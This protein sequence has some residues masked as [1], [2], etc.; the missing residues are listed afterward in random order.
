MKELQRT[1]F[2]AA[3]D[4]VV[5][6]SGNSVTDKEQREMLRKTSLNSGD[7]DELTL[8]EQMVL[9]INQFRH[10]YD[11]VPVAVNDDQNIQSAGGASTHIMTTAVGGMTS[12]PAQNEYD[13][14]HKESFFR[15]RVLVACSLSMPTSPMVLPKLC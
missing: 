5:F 2:F 10:L 13:K 3:Y 1:V 4:S 9:G 11:D 14:R 8:P 7:P 12:S 15:R 6:C